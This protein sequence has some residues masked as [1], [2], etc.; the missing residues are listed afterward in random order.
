MHKGKTYIMFT[1]IVALA[2]STML[3]IILNNNVI[4]LDRHNINVPTDITAENA[5]D[6][7]LALTEKISMLYHFIYYWTLLR[8]RI[9][10][11]F[12]Y[13]AMKRW[14]IV[15]CFVF[16]LMISAKNMLYN[17]N[18]LQM[19]KILKIGH[20]IYGYQATQVFTKGQKSICRS[21]VRHKS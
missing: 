12:P 9:F 10:L 16:T 14:E 7:V 19:L 21:T 18:I 1:V 4:L 11:Y 17:Q 5:Y 3:I 15:D 8:I 6:F 2:V 20:L 13:T